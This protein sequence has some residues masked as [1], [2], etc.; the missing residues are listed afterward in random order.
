MRPRPVPFVPTVVIRTGI[1][2]EDMFRGIIRERFEN[3]NI[4]MEIEPGGI[5]KTF[6]PADIMTLELLT[7]APSPQGP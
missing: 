1:N 3:G 6:T 5:F 7:N 2:P 4:Y